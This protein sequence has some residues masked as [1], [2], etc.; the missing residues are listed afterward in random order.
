MIQPLTPGEKI[1][2]ACDYM[3]H[4]GIKMGKEYYKGQ[5]LKPC[6]DSVYMVVFDQMSFNGTDYFST[7]S[8]T[9]TF[10][11]VRDIVKVI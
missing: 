11:N 9:T 7:G 1:L 6:S 3:N 4:E 2:F 10:I 8:N 5:I